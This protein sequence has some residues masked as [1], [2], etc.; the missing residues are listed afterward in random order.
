MADVQEGA[1][2]GFARLPEKLGFARHV[3][4]IFYGE[5]E[6]QVVLGFRVGEH[7]VN[8]AGM[9]HGGML[10]TVMDLGLI[11]GILAVQPHGTFA[12][13]MSLAVDFIAP[14]HLG[15]W[16]ESRVDFVHAAKRRGISSGR[17]V[18]P[19]GVLL[20]ANG[21]FNFPK[22]DDPRFQVG[23]PTLRNLILEHQQ[24]IAAKQE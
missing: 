9:C 16:V 20:R 6:G 23:T 4:P 7:H 15:D 14:A 10:M 12:P 8:P 11:L 1:P 5:A 24:R 18:G 2:P 3:G 19:Q 13:T 21:T 22:A 17:L